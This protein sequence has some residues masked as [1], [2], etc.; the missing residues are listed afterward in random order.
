MGSVEIHPVLMA[1]ATDS[2][3]TRQVHKSPFRGQAHLLMDEHNLGLS[4]G[5]RVTV[6]K[7][8]LKFGEKGLTGTA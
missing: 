3:A 2:D 4:A 6:M 7:S 5:A 1:S 8:C